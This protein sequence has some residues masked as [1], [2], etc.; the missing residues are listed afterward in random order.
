M[1]KGFIDDK[2]DVQLFLIQLT[3]AHRC[4]FFRF[5]TQNIL[6]RNGCCLLFHLGEKLFETIIVVH[7]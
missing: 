1:L 3:R 4:L 2:Y 7:R 5:S 6:I